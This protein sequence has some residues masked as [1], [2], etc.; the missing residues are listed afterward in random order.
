MIG[1]I[2]RLIDRSFHTINIILYVSVDTGDGTDPETATETIGSDP[3]APM[4][5][6]RFTK[7]FAGS[8]GSAFDRFLDG[9][10]RSVRFFGFKFGI[11]KKVQ[12][13]I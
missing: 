9:Q 4:S 7:L 5:R 12:I 10:F 1:V 3:V 8:S 13:A 2:D 11:S 6:W